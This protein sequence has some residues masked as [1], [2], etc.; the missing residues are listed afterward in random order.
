[1]ANRSQE[2]VE[3]AKKRTRRSEESCCE[4]LMHSLRPFGEVFKLVS[5]SVEIQNDC[6]TLKA[7][8]QMWNV[9]F[10]FFVTLT[11]FPAMMAGVE[12]L[13]STF[14]SGESNRRKY[15]MYYDCWLQPPIS[16]R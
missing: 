9:F 1:M 7:W 2:A 3:Q 5:D 13:D 14:W 12:P 16:H 15:E 8:V 10:V 11:I 6:V 4:S